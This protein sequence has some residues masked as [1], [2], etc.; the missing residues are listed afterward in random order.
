V[1]ASVYMAHDITCP[2]PKVNEVVEYCNTNRLPLVVGGDANA[3][4]TL[5][6]SSDI[7]ER[8]IQLLE[9]IVEQ[10]LHCINKGHKPN[11]VTSNTKERLD[12]TLVSNDLITKVSFWKV[13]DTESMSDHKFI[14]FGLRIGR[15]DPIYYRN[16]RKTMWS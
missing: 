14:Q 12:V 7:N 8:G 6:G 11:F 1:Y 10:D 9:F 5:W 3:H 2:P 15:P 16:R 4:H 13:L